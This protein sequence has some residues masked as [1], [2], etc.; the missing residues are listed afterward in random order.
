MRGISQ[1][2]FRESSC[3]GDSHSTRYASKAIV[4]GSGC[5]SIT[6]EI[7]L[8]KLRTVIKLVNLDACFEKYIG[9][10]HAPQDYCLP[11]EAG[12]RS[13][14]I[15]QSSGVTPGRMSIEVRV[16]TSRHRSEWFLDSKSRLYLRN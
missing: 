1:Y 10:L 7:L 16:V 15:R 5:N 13:G 6:V 12:C 3:R 2:N 4:S 11:V 14:G 8:A 9:F